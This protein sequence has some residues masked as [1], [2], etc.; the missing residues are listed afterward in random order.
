MASI[1]FRDFYIKYQGHPKYRRDLLIEDDIISVI[2][3][4]YEMILFTNKGEV[5]GLPDFGCDLEK[6]LF[7]TRVSAEYV[8]DIIIRQIRTYIPELVNMNYQLEVKFVEDLESYQE[9][10]FIYFTL[11]DYE[12]FARIGERYSTSF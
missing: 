8:R 9:A 5:L 6:F 3:Q 1:D 12:V 4:K 2:I 7:Q 10:M 11:A